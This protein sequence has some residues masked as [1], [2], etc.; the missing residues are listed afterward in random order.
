VRDME[1]LFLVSVGT[2]ILWLAFGNKKHW[3]GM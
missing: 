3:S 2:A 1:V